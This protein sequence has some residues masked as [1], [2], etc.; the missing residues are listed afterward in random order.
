MDM[1][2]FNN[3][4]ITTKNL[5]GFTYLNYHQ[6]SIINL[7]RILKKMFMLV[8]AMMKFDNIM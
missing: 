4:I 2:T 5:D 1:L 3:N 8:E 7:T 6:L